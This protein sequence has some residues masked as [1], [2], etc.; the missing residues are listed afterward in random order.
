MF[1]EQPPYIKN[2]RWTQIK[3]D[4]LETFLRA[5]VPKEASA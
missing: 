4:F 1:P 5:E 2:R 3:A